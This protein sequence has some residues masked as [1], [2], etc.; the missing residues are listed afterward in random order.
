MKAA[1]VTPLH[2]NRE[3]YLV[4]N[5]RPISLLITIS[6]ILEKVVYKRTYNFL[7]NTGQL[8]QSQYGFRSGHSCLNVIS[9]LVGNIQKNNEENKLTLG[10]FIDL[11][12]AFDTLS[13]SILLKNS[14]IKG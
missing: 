14:P 7:S 8:Y 5:Y 6:K 11:S 1:D 10:V 9:E 2:K 4:T 13:H 12:K 3:T